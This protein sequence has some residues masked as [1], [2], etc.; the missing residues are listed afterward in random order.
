MVRGEAPD[1]AAVV[2]LED[3][4]GPQEPDAGDD[5]LEHAG[6]VA[7][8]GAGLLGMRTNSAAPSDTSMWV[9]TPA[10][11]PARLHSYPRAPPSRAAMSSRISTRAA[12]PTS[13]RSE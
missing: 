9:R 11:L 1:L 8:G 4:P 13:G 12:W 6:D 2:D 7:R 5:A 3:R 10:G